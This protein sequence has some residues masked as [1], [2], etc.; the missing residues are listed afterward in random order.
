MGICRREFGSWILG[1]LAA[2]AWA[3]PPRVPKLLVLVVLEQLRPDHLEGLT[4]QFRPGGL[5][6][7]LYKGAQF[8]DCRHLASTFSASSV[9]TLATGA[10]PSQHGIVA[11]TWYDPAAKKTVSASSESLLATTLCEQV[12]ADPRNRVFVVSMDL[13]LA[14]LFAG[15]AQ[16]RLFWMDQG[17][18]FAT[19][20]PTPDWLAN[21]NNVHPL[22]DVHNATWMAI[23]ARAGAPPLRT[24]T[25]DPQHPQ[26][27]LALYKASH[28]CEEAQ[29]MFLS[30][31]IA[32]EQ[33]GQ[34]DT[35]DFV[36]LLA[37]SSSLLG[38][39][40][41]G[42]SPL[43]RQMTLQL[44]RHMEFLLDHLN[45]VPGE[46]AF[47][48]VLAGAH[49]A[50]PAP[51]PETRPRLAVNG[52]RVAQSVDHTLTATGAGHVTRYVY[53]FLYLDSSGFRDPEPIRIAAG[54]AALEQAAIA[55]YY[56]AGGACS[57]HDGWEKRFR[58]SFHPK[59][60][61]DVMLS[62]RP[63]Y[64]EDYGQGRGISYGSLYNYDVRVPLC[65]YG[66]QFQAGVFEGPVESVDLAPTLARVMGVA[67]PSSASGRVLAEAFAE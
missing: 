54:R 56:T 2:D 37:G 23:G 9:A 11:G 15:S 14:S 26:E 7:L 48:L 17:G 22:E 65:F 3:L 27:F 31:L 67:Q 58:N 39:E 51:S 53:P 66:P 18:R 36:C 35:F 24:L 44:D 57:T 43:M 62:Y 45:T 19:L 29:F 21:F 30:E 12:A 38:Y 42:G 13:S 61:G 41:G 10:W 32:R 16:A 4:S 28:L 64:I 55:G 59:R 49:G 8:P 50:P 60:S 6:R 25:F 34:G 20:G 1:G 52:E 46:N 63:E 40:I 47:N 5:R 33:I